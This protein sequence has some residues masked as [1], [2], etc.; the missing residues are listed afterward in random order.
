MHGNG[1][2]SHHVQ[3]KE[4]RRLKG[5][6][7]TGSDPASAK[8]QSVVE[9]KISRGA[10]RV[11]QSIDCHFFDGKGDRAGS[12]DVSQQLCDKLRGDDA[13]HAYIQAN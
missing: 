9:P 2:F 4:H 1:G 11:K 3:T 6:E 13:R 10:L 7:A 12:R 8:K 5:C